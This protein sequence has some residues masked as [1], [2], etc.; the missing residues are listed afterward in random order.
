M[1]Y[2]AQNREQWQLLEN[3]VIKLEF[4]KIRRLPCLAEEALVSQE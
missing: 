3:V 4:R 2:L 1:D